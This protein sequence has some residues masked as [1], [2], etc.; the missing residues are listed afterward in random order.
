MLQRVLIAMAISAEAELIVADEPTSALDVTVQAGI[1]DLLLELQETTGVAIMMITHDLG[2]ARLMSDRIHVMQG[3]RFVESGAAEQ[4]VDHPQEQYTPGPAGRDS[5][6]GAVGRPGPRTSR[7][8]CG[9]SSRGRAAAAAAPAQAPSR[10]AGP[11]SEDAPESRGPRGGVPA[12]GKGVFR[13][14]DGSASRWRRGG[15]LAVVGES[16]CGKSTIART[17]VRLNK[18][19]SGTIEFD[20]QNIGELTEKQL[21][22]QR[23]R[24]QMVFQDPYG[25]LDPHLTAQQIVAEPLKVRGGISAKEIKER[26]D[27]LIER[28]GLPKT[29]LARKPSEFSGGQRQRIGIAR[30]LASE[31]ELLVCDEATSALDVS[32]QAQVLELLADIQRETEPHLHL[33]LAQPRRG[34]GDFAEH[35]RDARRVGSSNPGTTDQ[36]LSAPQQEYTQRLRRSALEPG[37]DDR[38]ET[39]RHRAGHRARPGRRDGP[40]RRATRPRADARHARPKED[41]WSTS[42]IPGVPVQQSRLVLGTMT[43]GDTVDA[44]LAKRMVDTAMDA[45]ITALD[46]AN[47]YAGGKSEEISD[48]C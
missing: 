46:T 15:T 38:P 23:H 27:R 26:A 17:L 45:G 7:A 34:A 42:D 33:H 25:S 31:P 19:T 18:P 8:G 40:A 3:G 39:A 47:G 41:I 43:F 35:D 12:S 11:M 1:L 16:G 20:G 48:R 36:V 13:A 2:V 5:R 37:L 29:A 24:I 22:P 30:A 6:P 4:I 44:D 10:G 32:V 21:R 28:V 9:G 14:V